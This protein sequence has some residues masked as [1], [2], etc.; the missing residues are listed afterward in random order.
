MQPPNRLQLRY[1]LNVSLLLLPVN[2][3]WGMVHFCQVTGAAKP[4]ISP[5]CRIIPVRNGVITVPFRLLL[6]AS[7]GYSVRSKEV[8]MACS[9]SE[10]GLHFIRRDVLCRSRNPSL[11]AA[12]LR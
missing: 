3:P 10:E 4:E 6:L 7:L 12:I 8:Q 2:Q 11:S 1:I 9:C 5:S